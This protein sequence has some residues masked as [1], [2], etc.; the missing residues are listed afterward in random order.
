LHATKH[1]RPSKLDNEKEPHVR[2]DAEEVPVLKQKSMRRKHSKSQSHN[3][4]NKEDSEAARKSRRRRRD[5]SRRGLQILFDDEQHKK[6]EEEKV[7]DRLL[8]H[9]CKNPSS[10]S[11]HEKSR[12]RSKSHHGHQMD[13]GPDKTPDTVPRAPRSVSLLHEQTQEVQVN[14]M[15]TRAASFQ[16][17]RSKEARH[18]SILYF[19]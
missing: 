17:D 12:R 10:V 7:I 11:G 8:L 16:P 1:A 9:Y 14:K 19:Y 4:A 5:K 3:D 18:E 2:E 6:D 15:F 13:D